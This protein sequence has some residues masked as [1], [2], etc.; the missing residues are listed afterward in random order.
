MFN[1]VF[2]RMKLCLCRCEA[3]KETKSRKISIYY[4]Q[5]TTKYILIFRKNLFG[6][7]N[8]QSGLDS[9]HRTQLDYGRPYSLQWF[10]NILGKCNL[11]LIQSNVMRVYV[12]ERNTQMNRENWIEKR[13][14]N[15]QH[16][17]DKIVTKPLTANSLYIFTS[18]RDG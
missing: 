16:P 6:S 3:I 15:L 2:Q 9:N 8:S 12:D 1:F 14:S 17:C 11:W 4:G 5:K 13:F 10:Q 7:R 18:F